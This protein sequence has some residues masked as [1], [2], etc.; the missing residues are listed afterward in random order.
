MAAPVNGP[1]VE[2]ASP[3]SSRTAAARFGTPNLVYARLRCLET[4]AELNPNFRP[5]WASVSPS[6]AKARICRCRAVSF[7]SLSLAPGQSVSR[8]YWVTEWVFQN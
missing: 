7:D 2:C 4:V 5:I 8:H 1:S 6:A 3:R